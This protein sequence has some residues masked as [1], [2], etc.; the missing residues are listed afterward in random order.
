[1]ARVTVEDCMKQEG[2]SDRYEL[3]ILASKRAKDIGSGSPILIENDNEKNAV[4]SL[5]EIAAHKFEISALKES[6]IQSMMTSNKLHDGDDDVI[7]DEDNDLREEIMEELSSDFQ[8]IESDLD[9]DL[10]FKEDGY[11]GEDILNAGDEEQ[12]S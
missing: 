7:L 2:I 6:I 12:D 5:R 4:V 8:P 1:M 10:D 9:D 11:A 3:V